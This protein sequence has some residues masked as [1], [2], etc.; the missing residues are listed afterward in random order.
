MFLYEK[1]N[2]N[3]GDKHIF[4]KVYIQLT[5]R[6][7][8]FPIHIVIEHIRYALKRCT[9]NRCIYF[10]SSSILGNVNID[11]KC[12]NHVISI[13]DHLERKLLICFSQLLML[14]QIIYTRQHF[15]EEYF[16]FILRL[17][18]L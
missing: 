14:T 13:C 7:H 4:T 17:S 2:V 9:F 10:N 6:V 8:S 3:I 5:V 12:T 15:S 16:H 18:M 1:G 11:Q